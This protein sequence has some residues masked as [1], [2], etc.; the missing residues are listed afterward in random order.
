[1]NRHPLRRLVL[2]TAATVGGVVLLLS[3]K[4]SSPP[5]AVGLPA[6]APPAA[7]AP[8]QPQQDAPVPAGGGEPARPTPDGGNAGPKP[9]SDAGEAAAPRT[10]NGTTV[11]TEYGPVQVQITVSGRRI[12]AAAALQKPQGGRSD[13]VSGFAIPKLN[14]QAVAAQSADIDA[15][16]GASY[17]SDGYRKSLQSALDRV[18]G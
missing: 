14:Q 1:M 9:G 2:A 10:V 16:S 12:T 7:G 4:P 15:V 6:P 5:V 11:R 13:Q 17:T 8:R 18:G 3:L